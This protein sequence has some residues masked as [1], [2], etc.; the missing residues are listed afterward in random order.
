MNNDN[1]TSLTKRM[2]EMI[3]LANVYLNH[4]PKHEKYG[5][6]LQ[7]RQSMYNIYGMIV[8]CQKK[9]HKKTT[10][11][12]LDIEHEKLRMFW[13]LYFEMG[14][15]NYHHNKRAKT[16]ME[17]YHRYE[18]ISRLVDEVGAMIGGWIKKEREKENNK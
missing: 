11:T 16:E 8:E 7:I 1:T 2:T 17:A 5:L 15:F 10:L 9:Y 18:A 14:Y 4:A 12:N 13:K 3:E 6:C